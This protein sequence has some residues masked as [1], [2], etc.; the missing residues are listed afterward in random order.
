MEVQ[1]PVRSFFRFL[2]PSREEEPPCFCFRDI[3]R[4]WICL[5]FVLIG[6]CVFVT[7]FVL[8]HSYSDSMGNTPSTL[9]DLTLAHWLDV[10]DTANNNSVSVKRNKW[11]TLSSIKWPSFNVGWQTGGTF[12]YGQS[13]T[14]YLSPQCRPS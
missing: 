4:I 1:I 5:F 10:K 12:D 3:A 11:V 13:G 8:C 6:A 9:L 7:L 14:D 2:P